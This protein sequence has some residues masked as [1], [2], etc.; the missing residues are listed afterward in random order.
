[1]H[2]IENPA[3]REEIQIIKN[4]V[5]KFNE[6]KEKDD[7]LSFI[8]GEGIF[9]VKESKWTNGN[10]LVVRINTSK[11]TY[12]VGFLYKDKHEFLTK[13]LVSHGYQLQDN[14]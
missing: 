1:M 14:K 3:A 9:S 6:G 2:I 8:E 11:N 12:E 10:M 13:Y 7:Q 5:K 4:E